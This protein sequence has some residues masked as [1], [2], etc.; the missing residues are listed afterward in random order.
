MVDIILV[1]AILSILWGV[2]SS[3][4]ITIYLSN[5]GIKI[6]YFLIKILIIK[7]ANQY[8]KITKEEDGKTGP[9]FYSIVGSMYLALVLAII[10]LVLKAKG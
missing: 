10:G 4:K 1:L 8:R 7:Y 2:F 5:R 6:N 9:W 3:I